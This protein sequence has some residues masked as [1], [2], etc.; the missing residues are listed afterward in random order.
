MTKLNSA[1]PKGS[2]GLTS[3]AT[4]MIRTPEEL[5]VVIALIDCS[6]I[7]TDTD[8]G[9]IEPTARIIRVEALTDAD[10]PAALAMFRAAIAKRTGAAVLTGMESWDEDLAAAFNLTTGEVLVH[11]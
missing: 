5:H 3:L 6:S 10:K 7:K 2:N 8:T 9:D 4:R 1:L 11:D